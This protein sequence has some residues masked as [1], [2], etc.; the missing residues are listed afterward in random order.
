[1]DTPVRLCWP[2]PALERQKENTSSVLFGAQPQNAKSQMDRNT[3]H[4][5]FDRS[6][7]TMDPQQKQISSSLAY[8]QTFQQISVEHF[9][10]ILRYPAN[11]QIY[12]PENI[13]SLIEIK[14]CHCASFVS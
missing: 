6:T 10:E 2:Y 11:K 3:N 12:D 9:H 8:D 1:M 4:A 7:H 13:T 14:M 5:T